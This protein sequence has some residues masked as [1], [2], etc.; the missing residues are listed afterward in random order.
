MATH[1]C[2]LLRALLP[3]NYKEIIFRKPILSTRQ[4]TLLIATSSKM[5][6]F[7]QKW[8]FQSIWT[9]LI[10]GIGFNKA[11]MGWAWVVLSWYLMYLNTL[12]LI[13]HTPNPI[14]IFHVSHLPRFWPVMEIVIDKKG[15]IG[16]L[17]STTQPVDAGKSCSL[18][19]KMSENEEIYTSGKNF[20]RPPAVSDKSHLCASSSCTNAAAAQ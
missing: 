4:M 9:A 11:G 1:A 13:L 19:A 10:A 8:N 12:Y 16:Q 3:F 14:K 20:T 2:C 5:L 6:K 17:T 7:C 18:L 15:K